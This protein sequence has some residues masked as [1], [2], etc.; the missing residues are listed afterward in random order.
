M[1]LAPNR[2][3]V[4]GAAG[5][6]L[7]LRGGG[8]VDVCKVDAVGGVV[9]EAGWFNGAAGLVDGSSCVSIVG[10]GCSHEIIGI[11]LH[12]RNETLRDAVDRQLK[13]G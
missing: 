6:D 7:R 1:T 9:R 3:A 10:D 8:G 13:C 4:D 11:T 2:N 12:D 5:G